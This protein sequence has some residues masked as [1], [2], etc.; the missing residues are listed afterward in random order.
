MELI[1]TSGQDA[2]SK[3]MQNAHLLQ[4]SIVHNALNKARGPLRKKDRKCSRVQGCGWLHYLL[5]IIEVCSGVDSVYKS[6][7]AQDLSLKEERRLGAQ[8]YSHGWRFVGDL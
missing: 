4:K 2:E 5:D 1:C 7:R 8:P 3:V 6:V